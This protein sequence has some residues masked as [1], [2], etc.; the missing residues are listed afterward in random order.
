MHTSSETT[1]QGASAPYGLNGDHPQYEKFCPCCKRTIHSRE[2][3][4]EVENG[5]VLADLRFKR[6]REFVVWTPRGIL[7]V[8]IE[9]DENYQVRITANEPYHTD[10]SARFDTAHFAPGDALSWKEARNGKPPLDI[11]ASELSIEDVEQNSDGDFEKAQDEWRNG[12]Y[13]DDAA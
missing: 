10:K 1:H 3:F 13:Y 8:Y 5:P 9:L 2:T 4:D 7:R 11:I 6:G 12:T